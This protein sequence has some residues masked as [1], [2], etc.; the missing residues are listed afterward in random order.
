[1][2]T[3]W[4]VLSGRS[5]RGG[6]SDSDLYQLFAYTRRYGCARSILLYPHVS[7]L[8]P[9]DFDVLDE[10][11][12]T[13]PRVLVRHVRLHRNLA[14]EKERLALSTN[15]R[16]LSAK[17]SSCQRPLSSACTSQ[18]G[19]MTP[20]APAAG[21]RPGTRTSFDSIVEALSKSHLSADE[22][23]L[24]RESHWKLGEDARLRED[25]RFRETPWGR[26]VAATSFVANDAAV[27]DSRK[28]ASSSLCRAL[29]AEREQ[30]IRAPLCLCALVTRASSSRGPEYVWPRASSRTNLASRTTSQP[31]EIHDAP[32]TPHA[33][34]GGGFVPAG[35]GVAR[36]HEEVIDTLGWV[37][38]TLPGRL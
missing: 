33:Q 26:W 11:G 19:G 37:R 22:T 6:V 16:R 12:H 27:E 32:A 38:V 14:E 24:L 13:G 1:M 5:T 36:A 9:R 23:E 10:Q 20:Y 30:L 18:D 28:G 15:W 4:K 21:R 31:R 7:G 3:K 34:S 8:E 35:N 25:L 17:D 2:D 29:L